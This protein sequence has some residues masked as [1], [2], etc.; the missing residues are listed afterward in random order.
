M[1]SC[2]SSLPVEMKTLSYVTCR[3]QEILRKVPRQSSSTGIQPFLAPAIQNCNMR[4][5]WEQLACPFAG[6]DTRHRAVSSA[7]TSRDVN[8]MRP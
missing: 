2:F 3:F 8:E 4:K 1:V 6:S 7:V 5:I